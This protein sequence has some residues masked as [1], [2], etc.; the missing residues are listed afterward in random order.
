[1]NFYNYFLML[2]NEK[3]VKPSRAGEDI[4]IS[5]T[6]VNGWKN[7][8]IPTDSN[9]QLLADYFGVTIEQFWSCDDV[10]RNRSKEKS[11]TTTFNDDLA[12][13]MQILRDSPKSRSVLRSTKGMTEEQL[14]AVETLIKQLR[15]S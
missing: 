7:G 1:M 2:C 11:Q 13:E 5:K 15:R 8:R 9:L 4:D 6:A 3:G 10:G 14:D 12:E